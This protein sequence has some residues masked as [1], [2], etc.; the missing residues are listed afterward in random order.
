MAIHRGLVLGH[1]PFRFAAVTRIGQLGK[2]HLGQA[3]STA[4]TVICNDAAKT[5][6]QEG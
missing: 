1:Q 5:R 6:R 4:I 2:D 3:W